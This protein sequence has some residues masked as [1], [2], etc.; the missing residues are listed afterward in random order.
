METTQKALIN[1]TQT[2]PR[3]EWAADVIEGG[4]CI[5]RLSVFRAGAGSGHVA[6]VRYGDGE[7]VETALD[8]IP[9]VVEVETWINA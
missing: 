1:K 4:E 2:T 6:R 7:T 3:G 9:G 8:H 5:A